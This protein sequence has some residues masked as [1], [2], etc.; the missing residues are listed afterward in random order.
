MGGLPTLPV[1]CRT[2]SEFIMGI[3]FIVMFWMKG[4]RKGYLFTLFHHHF[5]FRISQSCQECNRS[6]LWFCILKTAGDLH[7]QITRGNYNRRKENCISVSSRILNHNKLYTWRWPIRP[8][9]VVSNKGI[10][11]K[12]LWTMLHTDGIKAPKSVPSTYL[13]TK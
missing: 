9:H 7:N 6:V 3:L 13:N 2:V 4:E 5:H 10:R 11:K 12:E 1:I 8:K